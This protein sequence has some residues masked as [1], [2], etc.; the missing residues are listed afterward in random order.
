MHFIHL[1]K[2]SLLRKIDEIHYIVK[3]TNVTVIGLS[4]TK[5]DNIILSRGGESVTCFVKNSFH[6]IGNLIFA[7]I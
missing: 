4:K 1:N 2:N 6:I 7:L 3:L 5:L